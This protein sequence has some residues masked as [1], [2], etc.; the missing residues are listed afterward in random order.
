[1]LFWK[2]FHVWAPA[3]RAIDVLTEPQQLPKHPA[4]VFGPAVGPHQVL[5]C[6]TAPF[7]QNHFYDAT[8]FHQ[9]RAAVVSC[10]HFLLFYWEGCTR[11]MFST[12]FPHH[13]LEFFRLMNKNSVDSQKNSASDLYVVI[14]VDEKSPHTTFKYFVPWW[15][16]Q[17]LNAKSRLWVS[18]ILTN[19]LQKR[20]S[21]SPDHKSEAMV[22]LEH[23]CVVYPWQRPIPHWKTQKLQRRPKIPSNTCLPKSPQLCEN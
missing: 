9:L 3:L 1:M 15:Q 7:S 12:P 13:N 2:C 16:M 5:A 17:R 11:N 21:C 14:N 23:V 20:I 18:I 22:L 10:K 8:L 4:R 6:C 19:S